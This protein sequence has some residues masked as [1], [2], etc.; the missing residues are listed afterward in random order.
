MQAREHGTR[1]SFTEGARRAQ[2]V[3]AAIETIAEA[4]FRHATF[5]RIAERA[6]LSSTGLISYHF[7]GPGR[8]D[9]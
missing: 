5:A 1:R 6:G 3:Q 9:G 4:G 7:A 2:I 8:A